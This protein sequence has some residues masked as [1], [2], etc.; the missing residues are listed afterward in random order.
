MRENPEE[1]LGTCGKIDESQSFEVVD[2]L[3]Q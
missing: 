1:S 2:F 3:M